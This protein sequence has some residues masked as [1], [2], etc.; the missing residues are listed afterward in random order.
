MGKARREFKKKMQIRRTLTDLKRRV[1]TLEKQKGEYLEKAKQAKLKGN[2]AQYSLA[3]SG[4]RASINQIT[5]AEQMLLNIELANQ[6]R[7]FDASGKSFVKGMNVLSKEL[8]RSSRPADFSRASKAFGRGMERVGEAGMGLDEL[9]SGNTAVLDGSGAG[10]LSDSELDKLIDSEVLGA[11]SGMDMEIDRM[12]REFD[13]KDGPVRETS[14]A[15]ENLY[16]TPESRDTDAQNA[17]TPYNEADERSQRGTEK[18]ENAADAG[19]KGVGVK[20]FAQ[21]KT[22]LSGAALRPERLADYIGQP[23]AV[24]ALADPIKK[25]MYTD[26]PLPHI[27]LCGSHGQGK[28][29]LAKIIAKE[30]GGNFIEVS[31]S[32]RT[33]DLLRII[34]QVKEGDIIFIDEIHRLAAEVVESVLYPAIEDFEAHFTEVSGSKTRNVSLK[35]PR[36]TLVGATTESGRLLKPFYSKF[37]IKCTL[38]EYTVDFIANIVVNS[39]RAL[40]LAIT[41]EAALNVAGRSRLT[42]R[43]ANAYVNGIASSEIVRAAEKKGITEKGALKD[44]ARIAELNIVVEEAAVEEYFNKIGVDKIGLTEFDRKLLN[45]LVGKY[46]GGPVGQENLAKSLNV[47]VNR[48]DQEYEPHLVKLG[49]LNVRPQGRYATPAAY[50]YLGL[51]VPEDKF[52]SE[53]REKT[54]GCEKGAETA[55][56]RGDAVTGEKRNAEFDDALP[57]WELAVSKSADEKR[58]AKLAALFTA[59]DN[60]AKREETL[61]ELFPDAAK[62]Y[63]SGA[64]NRC[65]VKLLGE[66]EREIYCDSKL[67]RRFVRYLAE[68]GFI[69][70]LKSEALELTYHSSAGVTRKYYPDFVAKLSDGRVTVF[71][72][73]NLSSMGYHLNID[74][75]EALKAYCE[76]NGYLYAEIAKDERAGA[77][78]SA[79]RLKERGIDGALAKFVA[80]RME[81]RERADGEGI[82]CRSDLEEWLSGNDADPCDIISLLLND[83]TLKNIDTTGNNLMITRQ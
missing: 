46:N 21:K 73:K 58:T 48:I 17:N 71:E 15:G 42:P 62:D 53:T 3:R 63:D 68:S 26:S 25:A 45:E 6:N 8:K 38:E 1:S 4:L 31:S 33:R 41:P 56:D 65:I 19:E 22:D 76:E 10:E 80:A 66:K 40:G 32:V 7:E 81:E 77:Y 9:L 14:H 27:L 43:Q 2:Q 59:P 57:V 50:R 55:G 79:E 5:R 13:K 36:F 49:F 75:Y 78:V 11:E 70:D 35:I 60:A 51:S 61:D 16:K 18:E 44:A 37:P 23:K 67:E 20:S 64:K 83:R 54:V 52:P 28:T 47:S 72:M 82:F 39:F 29:T 74:K 30:M 12:L 69:S 34:R 24:A